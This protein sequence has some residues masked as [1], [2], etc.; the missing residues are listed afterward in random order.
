MKA[1]LNGAPVRPAMR[2]G[3]PVGHV[4]LDRLHIAG[5]G[6]RSDTCILRG[7]RLASTVAPLVTSSGSAS[8]LV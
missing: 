2:P 4:C 5:I 3:C 6:E 8:K 7:C 1:A